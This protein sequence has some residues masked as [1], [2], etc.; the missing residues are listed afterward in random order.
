MSREFPDFID[1]WRA[2]EGKKR[3]YGT[4]PL[5]RMKR[6]GP[7]LEA[8]ELSAAFEAEF[9]F[10]RQRRVT[11]KITVEALLTL[12]CQRSLEPF[13]FPV[14]QTSCLQVI[15][16]PQDQALL[17]DSEEF[18]TAESGRLAILDLVEDELLL[19]VPQVPRNPNIDVVESYDAPSQHREGIADQTQS[20]TRKPFERLAELMKKE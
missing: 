6:L 2:A 18:V 17:S 11:V 7:L 15:S 13:E 4:I 5:H 19:A 8:A 9:A 16:G 3:F 14:S 12:M 20:T 10:D 1:P